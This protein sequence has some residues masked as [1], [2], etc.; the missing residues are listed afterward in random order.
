MSRALKL[1]EQR[2]SAYEKE[3]VAVAYY[4][5]QW[6]HYLVGCLGGVTVVMDHQPLTHRM[7]L[8]VLS[9]MQSR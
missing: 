9:Q 5:I 7:E 4:C 6:R 3:L 8:Q 1:T 2:Y